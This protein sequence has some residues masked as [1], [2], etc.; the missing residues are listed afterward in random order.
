M[1]VSDSRIWS[2]SMSISEVSVNSPADVPVWPLKLIIFFAGLHYFYKVW[3]RF[4]GA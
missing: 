4:L 2:Q 1:I 3:L